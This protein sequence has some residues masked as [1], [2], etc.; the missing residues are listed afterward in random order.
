M[1]N[2]FAVVFII[3][4]IFFICTTGSRNALQLKIESIIGFIKSRVRNRNDRLFQN[5]I[6]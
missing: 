3:I 2:R 1:N 4:I 5:T 6:S